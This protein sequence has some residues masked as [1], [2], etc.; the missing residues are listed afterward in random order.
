MNRRD[1]I[2]NSIVMIGG[3]PFLEYI[4]VVLASEKSLNSNVGEKKMKVLQSV[5]ILL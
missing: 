1:F 2:I 4:K 5:M 3:L